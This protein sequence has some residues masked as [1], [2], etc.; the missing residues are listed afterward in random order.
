MDA[1]SNRGNLDISGSGDA[2]PDG[3]PHV[4]RGRPL[5]SGDVAQRLDGIGIATPVSQGYGVWATRAPVG[6][7]VLGASQKDRCVKPRDAE[8]PLGHYDHAVPHQGYRLHVVGDLHRNAS[9]EIVK[10]ETGVTRLAGGNDVAIPPD[11][12]DNVS[13][14]YEWLSNMSRSRFC[15]LLLQACTQV[16]Q[17]HRC[18]GGFNRIL[19]PDEPVA[20]D[21][22]SGIECPGGDD[23]PLLP[24]LKS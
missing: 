22:W 6:Y 10:V 14:G 11:R 4:E 1:W 7:R 5:S 8:A 9:V 17:V 24:E 15:N 19:Q 23:L 18:S 13:T 20:M 3:T 21:G 2:G 12:P 16:K